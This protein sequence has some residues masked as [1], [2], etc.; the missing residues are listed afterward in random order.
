MQDFR[1]KYRARTVEEFLGNEH[2]KAL[3]K[4]FQ[5]KGSYPKSIV[6]HGTYG[7]GKTTLGR[8]IAKDITMNNTKL[9]NGLFGNIYEIDGTQCSIESIRRQFSLLIDYVREP[10]VIFVDE[11]QRMIERTQDIFLKVIEESDKL[12][13]IF[14]TT[15]IEK[16]DRGI[17]SRST[18]L[19]LEPPS[20]PIATDR[21]KT[22]A[23]ETGMRILDEAL[24]YL[25]ESLDANPR[26]CLGALYQLYFHEG[27]I[28][29]SVA[30]DILENCVV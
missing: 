15:D 7:T 27:V 25:V 13:F 14:A 21:L 28:T 3:Y 23:H 6:L 19:F 9:G 26:E 5:R 4:G 29:A 18:K 1:I 12:Y 30:K 2:I 20:I 11:A 16:I 17:L 22:I 8:I 24:S 10:S